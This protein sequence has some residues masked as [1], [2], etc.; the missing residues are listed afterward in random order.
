M[1]EILRAFQDRLRELVAEVVHIL[2]LE[3]KPYVLR[4]FQDSMI[5]LVA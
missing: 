4:T 2:F 1:L 5:K 3:L